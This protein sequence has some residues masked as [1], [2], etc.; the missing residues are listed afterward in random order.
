MHRPDEGRARL[1]FNRNLG[2]V[3]ANAVAGGRGG[4]EHN[5]FRPPLGFVAAAVIA[6]H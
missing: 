3:T 5:A 4:G 6:L 1:I 2:M